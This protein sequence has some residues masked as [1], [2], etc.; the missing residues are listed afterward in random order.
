M[1]DKTTAKA[2]RR[3]P[4]PERAEGYYWV[5]IYGSDPQVAHMTSRGRWDYFDRGDDETLHAEDPEL[6]VIS[7]PLEPPH[8]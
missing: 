5:T 3:K 8:A 1:I 6:V 2:R 4:A 7:G